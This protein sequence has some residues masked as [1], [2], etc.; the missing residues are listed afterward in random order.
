MFCIPCCINNDN[1]ID[2]ND[3]DDDYRLVEWLIDW[4]IRD[5]GL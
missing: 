5:T 3:E 4:L 1:E 2:D